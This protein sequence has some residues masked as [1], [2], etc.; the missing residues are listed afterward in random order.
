MNQLDNSIKLCYFA[1]LKYLAHWIEL[2][3]RTA[4]GQTIGYRR[5]NDIIEPITEKANGKKMLRWGF[6]EYI[7]GIKAFTNYMI[8]VEDAN[9]MNLNTLDLFCCY[10]DYL[11][12]DLDRKTA[13]IMGDIPYKSIGNEE[14]IECAA[15]KIPLYKILLNFILC[16]KP[17]S[18]TEFENI[19]FAR[20]SKFTKKIR[21][22]LEEC[23]TLQ[24]LLLNVYVHKKTQTAYIRI[25]GIKISIRRLLWRNK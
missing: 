4:D 8:D 3:C 17:K 20:S 19:S 21:K 10:F 12:E 25:L 11:K 15:P 1:T 14:H 6:N 13:N 23:P 2:L 18:I 24:K 22:L 5:N 16:R 7:E 9:S